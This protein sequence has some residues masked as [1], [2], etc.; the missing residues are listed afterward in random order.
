[1]TRALEKEAADVPDSLEFKP[2]RAVVEEAEMVA[3][4]NVREIAEAADKAAAVRAKVVGALREA[5][6]A[7]LSIRRTLSGAQRVLDSGRFKT[8]FETGKSGGCFDPKYR[9]RAEHAGLG[10]PETVDP[11]KRPIYGYFDTPNNNASAYGN[12]EF[13]LK[14]SVKARTTITAGDSLY[15]FKDQT[16]VGTPA[17]NPGL[18]SADH[19]IK[20]L[21][22][23]GKD[24]HVGYFEA[25]IQR[26]VRLRD[27]EKVIVHRRGM[28]GADTTALEAAL[29]KAGIPYEF[30]ETY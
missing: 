16:V 30:Q 10:V 24:A 6:A 8:Q 5:A 3:E 27:V 1:M 25:Q 21:H 18:G 7:P 19:N 13:R 22:A 12:I 14:E 20:E 26:G 15:N 2:A 4:R 28:Y 29:R 9:A 17:K 11:V 23:L